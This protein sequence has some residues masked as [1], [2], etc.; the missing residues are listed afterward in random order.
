[1]KLAR[2][3]PHIVRRMAL[4]GMTGLILFTMAACGEGLSD[5]IN[6]IVDEIT[7]Q[8]REQIEE[9]FKPDKNRDFY[10]L[11]DRVAD[12]HYDR[13]E[14]SD[15]WLAAIA[16]L[17]SGV[18]DE[19]L[20]EDITEALDLDIGSEETFLLVF[21]A[22]NE[23]DESEMTEDDYWMLAM[24]AVLSSLE[25]PYS[26]YVR[27]ED[28]AA[29]Q[30][31]SQE[32]FVGIGVGVEN[33]DNNIRIVHIFPNSPAEGAGIMPGDV[34]THVDGVDVREASY[35]MALS[36]V[37]GKVDTEVELGI[38]RPGLA[39]ILTLTMIRSVIPTPTAVGELIEVDA[40]LM[41]YLRINTFGNQTAA[42]TEEILEGF[43]AAGYEGLII[44]VRNNSGGALGTLNAL[45]ALFM[46]GS[47]D[48][49]FFTID[50][51]DSDTPQKFYSTGEPIVDVPMVLLTN[52]FS[53]SASEVFASALHER[54][55]VEI[56]GE[57][58]FGKGSVQTAFQLGGPLGDY[59]WLTVGNWFT[60]AGVNVRGVGY[61]PSLPVE[62]N[63]Y[64]NTPPIFVGETVYELDDEHELIEVA[65]RILKA[66][67]FGETLDVNGILDSATAAALEA[68][69]AANDMP[70]SGQLDPQ[71]AVALTTAIT[72]YRNNPDHDDQRQAAIAFLLGLLA[73]DLEPELTLP[74]L[75]TTGEEQPLA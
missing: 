46:Q 19:T 44:D 12:Y 33:A 56:L 34:I 61:E 53:A 70:L 37:L 32:S 11:F 39:S 2:F 68:F 30:Q 4:V 5:R 10:E 73:E 52:G 16:G 49:P 65:Q 28:F 45:L 35:E 26:R 25:D 23:F 74:K 29:L 24:F 9:Q 64:L 69:Q 72:A 20:V 27:F 62:Q 38:K 21:A 15:L 55:N 13:P 40:R 42:I 41:G 17:L 48:V 51:V 60:A 6:E 71:T 58:T 43:I 67:G 50:W 63:P 57:T 47:E 54:G 8:I 31:G 36:L 7:R 75:P 66:L 14:P 18:T 59:V 22:I 3:F 1:M